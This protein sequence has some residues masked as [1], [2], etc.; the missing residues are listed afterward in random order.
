MSKVMGKKSVGPIVPIYKA[1]VST[2]D[3]MRYEQT[4]WNREQFCEEI[5]KNGFVCD[6]DGT[7][8]I[9]AH[10]IAHVTFERVGEGVEW[11]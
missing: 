5:H 8:W 1:Y 2:V 3:G 6:D 7:S 9:P 11:K 10:R 4:I